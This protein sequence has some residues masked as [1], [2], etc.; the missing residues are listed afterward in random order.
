MREREAG[1]SASRSMHH[2][3][4]TSYRDDRRNAGHPAVNED[5]QASARSVFSV[6]G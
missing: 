6:A 3:V 1:N 4:L 5:L 2:H